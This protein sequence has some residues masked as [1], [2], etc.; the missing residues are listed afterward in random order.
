MH[1]EETALTSEETA[2]T[3]KVLLTT[4]DLTA[5]GTVVVGVSYLLYETFKMPPPMLP[6]YP[7]DSF[8]PQLTIGLILFC[9]ILL[10][11][12]RY[13]DHVQGRGEVEGEK[14]ETF[15]ID[16]IGFFVVTALLLLFP[17]LLP[18]L[19]FEI[20]TFSLLTILFVTRFNDFVTAETLN[21]GI[22]RRVLTKA[23]VMAFTTMCCL[24]FIFVI[25]LNV[26]MPVV[27][28]P[29]YINFGF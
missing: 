8:F 25:L 20:V 21:K 17:F 14:D 12:Y 3:S 16:V 24:Y 2:V 26:S 11:I 19:G 18:V 15:N 9:G 29:K 28:F 27:F 22:V 10:L 6:G 5:V 13:R 1:E 23:V 4:G 7:G